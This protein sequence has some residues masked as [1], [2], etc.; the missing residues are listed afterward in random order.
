MSLSSVLAEVERKGGI[1]S[2]WATGLYAVVTRK[3]G[4]IAPGAYQITP[5]SGP[6]SVLASLRRKITFKFRMP[7]HMWIERMAAYLQR[8]EICS[9]DEYIN[10]ANEELAAIQKA[11]IATDGAQGYLLPGDYEL[12]PGITAKEIVDLQFQEFQRQV[13]PKIESK[14]VNRILTIASMVEMEAKEDK[15]RPLIAGV[16]ENRIARNMPLQIDATVLYARK[17]WERRLTFPMIKETVSPY[18]TYLN[19]GLPPGP[20]CSPTLKSILA[21]MNPAHNNYLYYV[22]LP[23]GYHLFANTH[24]DHLKNILK[25]KAALAQIEM[26]QKHGI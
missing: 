26:E 12:E 23:N 25:R 3:D 20:I 18:N 19:K 6:N 24:E 11:G 15:D 4:E 7:P 16:I 5:G 13:A 14:D 22:A 10:A 9:A 2:S 1:R 21:A 8:K 17:K